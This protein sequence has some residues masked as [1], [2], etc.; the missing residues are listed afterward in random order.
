MSSTTETIIEELLALDPALAGHEEKL[1]HI[2]ETMI[3]HRP[4]SSLDERFRQELRTKIDRE[5]RAMQREKTSPR[6]SV[7]SWLV[8]FLF[9]G[10]AFASLMVVSPIGQYLHDIVY[11]TSTIKPV[12]TNE[13]LAMKEATPESISSKSVDT[14]STDAPTSTMNPLRGATG[15][16]ITPVPSITTTPANTQVI[17][18]N[19]TRTTD[20][21]KILAF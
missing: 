6:A 2:V 8:P 7:L 11:P 10:V 18:R 19:I 17:H 9:G 3:A 20:G 16:T 12:S 5:I 4:E 14:G 21:A 15:S 13:S 1:R